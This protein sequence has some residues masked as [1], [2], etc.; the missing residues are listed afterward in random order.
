MG[1]NYS[2]FARHVEASILQTL[3]YSVGTEMNKIETKSL[4]SWTNYLVEKRD[5]IQVNGKKYIISNRD[6]C[7]VVL[8]S[9]YLQYTRPM[10]LIFLQT[11]PLNSAK[12]ET[13]KVSIVYI[14]E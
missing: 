7:H 8:S 3:V 9:W 6:A 5:C 14:F 1:Y 4:F 13:Q 10:N 2:A 12:G 11:D